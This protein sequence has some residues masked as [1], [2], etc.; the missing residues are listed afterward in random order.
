MVMELEERILM[1]FHMKEG[2][3]ANQIQAKLQ[4]HFGA[5]AYALQIFRFWIGEIG[6]GREDFHDEHHAGRSP[7]DSIDTAIFEIIGKSPFDSARSIA[8]TINI[9]HSVVLHHFHE[10]LGFKCFHL[11]WVSHLLTD[12]LREKRKAVTRPRNLRSQ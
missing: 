3:D 1:K 9:W 7:F 2:F 4:T 11:R 12:D 6:G 5:K 8:Q 10:I